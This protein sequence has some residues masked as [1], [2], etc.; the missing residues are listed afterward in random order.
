M[1]SN[2]WNPAPFRPPVTLPWLTW[3]IFAL[4]LL[5]A[6]LARAHSDETPKYET[7]YDAIVKIATDLRQALGPKERQCLDAAPVLLNESAVPSLQPTQRADGTRTVQIS[8]GFVDLLN[9]L[10]HAKAIDGMERGFYKKSIAS[11]AVRTGEAGLPALPLA[12]K[13]AWSFDTLNHQASHFNQMA[14]ALVAIEMAHH[15]LGHYKKYAS[16]LSDAQNRSV[17]INSLLTPHE[18]H[19]AVMAGC[20][21]ALRCGLGVDGL[22]F[23]YEGLDKMPTRPEWTVCLLPNKAN[24]GK[25]RRELERTEKDFFLVSDLGR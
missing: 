21:N 24:V 15:Y 23:L 8:A 14:G 10:S 17:P 4:V 11:L 6:A 18:W 16:Q 1:M 20:Q 22:K 19:E 5:V 2:R 3:A 7:G 25:L 9:Y 13:D 12:N